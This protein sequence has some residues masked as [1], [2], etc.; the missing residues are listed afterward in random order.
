MEESKMQRKVMSVLGIAI[1]LV[2]LLAIAVPVVADPPPPQFPRNSMAPAGPDPMDLTVEKL[3]AKEIAIRKLAAQ[4]GPAAATH[5]S[6]IGAPANVGDEIT[7]MVSDD[8]L[9]TDYPETF[10]V[11]KDG[12]HGF[13]LIT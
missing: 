9:G 10:V 1:L 13:I 3:G 12:V 8:G 7:V 11:V 6:L 2:S 4:I 5:A